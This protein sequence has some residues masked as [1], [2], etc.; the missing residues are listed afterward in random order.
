M[1]TLVNV[2]FHGSFD[3]EY[4]SDIEIALPALRERGP[5]MLASCISGPR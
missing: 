5:S 1:R 4:V 2:C 3:D